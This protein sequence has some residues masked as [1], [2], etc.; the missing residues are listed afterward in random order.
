MLDSNMDELNDILGEMNDKYSRK[1][2]K[3]EETN[4]SDEDNFDIN[5]YLDENSSNKKPKKH[6]FKNQSESKIDNDYL[7]MVR[8]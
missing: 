2:A 1:S 4:L 8:G 6:H 5:M 7:N 3:K